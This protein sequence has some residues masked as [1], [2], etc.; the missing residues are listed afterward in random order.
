MATRARPGVSTHSF[1]PLSSTAVARLKLGKRPWGELGPET[2]WRTGGARRKPA[3]K[4]RPIIMEIERPQPKRICGVV[5]NIN[6]PWG[7]QRR[8]HH[9]TYFTST[10]A[11]SKAMGFLTDRV[12]KSLRKNRCTKDEG[13]ARFPYVCSCP[14]KQC[15]NFASGITN[16]SCGTISSGH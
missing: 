2:A 8:L 11:A 10:K 15:S 1:Y 14:P 9:G 6:P 7:N 16:R 5:V 13:Y 12:G 3:E 4:A